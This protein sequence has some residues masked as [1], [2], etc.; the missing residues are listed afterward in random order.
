MAI[1]FAKF[2]KH[3]RFLVVPNEWPPSLGHFGSDPP[4]NPS[5]FDAMG[6]V[7]SGI[8]VGLWLA[9]TPRYVAA[10]RSS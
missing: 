1:L 5:R 2:L 10:F 6:F 3:S 9:H 7:F 4:L 8:R